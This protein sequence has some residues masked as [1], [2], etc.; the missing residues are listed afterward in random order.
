MPT[1]KIETSQSSSTV[2]AVK[3]LDASSHLHMRV[4]PSGNIYKYCG[5]VLIRY[6]THLSARPGL[7][8]PYLVSSNRPNEA[9]VKSYI[10]LI[11]K[12]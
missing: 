10:I 6:G 9:I 1:V 11:R 8:N 12:L 4:C 2:V 7:F 5:C 3:S